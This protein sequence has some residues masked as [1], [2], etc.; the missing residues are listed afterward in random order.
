MILALS[1]IGL[2]LMLGARPMYVHLNET[3][4]FKLIDVLEVPIYYAMIFIMTWAIAYISLRLRVRSLNIR[5]F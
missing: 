4:L 2:M 3:F 5:D 1:Y